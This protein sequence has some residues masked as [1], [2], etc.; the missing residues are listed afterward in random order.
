MGKQAW[1]GLEKR[2]VPVMPLSSQE[3]ASSWGQ[4]PRNLRTLI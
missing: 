1:A 2:L 3:L 4:L